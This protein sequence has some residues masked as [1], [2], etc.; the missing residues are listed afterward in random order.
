MKEKMEIETRIMQES[1]R[2]FYHLSQKKLKEN[3]KT[4]K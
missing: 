2:T 3:I 4:P 1:S